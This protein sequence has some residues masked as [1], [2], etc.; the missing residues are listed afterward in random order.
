M[1][2]GESVGIIHPKQRHGELRR[3]IERVQSI[4]DVTHCTP[5]DVISAFGVLKKNGKLPMT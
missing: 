2:K 1:I 3:T 5:F 4:D